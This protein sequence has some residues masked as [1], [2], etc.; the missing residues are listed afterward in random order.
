MGILE[1]D[2]TTHMGV[3]AMRVLDWNSVTTYEPSVPGKNLLLA[4]WKT[5]SC[6][7]DPE[8][9][10]TT[11]DIRITTALLTATSISDLI[12]MELIDLEPSQVSEL[13]LL[14]AT[15]AAQL[16]QQNKPGLGMAIG[17]C[18]EVLWIAHGYYYFR[19]NESILT[20]AINLITGEHAEGFANTIK[21]YPLTA[22]PQN[23]IVRPELS[24]GMG[25]GMAVQAIVKA[26][27]QEPGIL[28]MLII[29]EAR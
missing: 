10:G 17:P 6:E 18:S 26:G 14:C 27:D 15:D 13:Y 28:D 3:D 12:A 2:D 20:S 24:L 9:I 7:L 8:S 19:Q 29:H 5:G 21:K 11:T 25:L 1:N 4:E 16:L 22:A 23:P